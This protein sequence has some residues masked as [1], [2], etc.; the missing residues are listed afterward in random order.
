L[1]SDWLQRC[2]IPKEQSIKFK[3]YKINGST[4]VELDKY[5]LK[6]MLHISPANIVDQILGIINVLKP[7]GS[8]ENNQQVIADIQQ[9]IVRY[10]VAT[11][12]PKN[13][14]LT[15]RT[16]LLKL[17]KQDTTN[18]KLNEYALKLECALISNDGKTQQ[19]IAD[20]LNKPI[21]WVSKYY[22]IDPSTLIM[23]DTSSSPIAS[24]I[25]E[26]KKNIEEKEMGLHNLEIRIQHE[27]RKM[28]NF[29]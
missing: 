27:R 8:L 13:Q 17:L 26:I 2:G 15:E 20:Q 16:R 12:E 22:K 19:Q 7:M 23:P 9:N 3:K 11:T 29:Y 6:T 5:K 21:T 4:F 24:E 28:D 1:I 14:I 10:E 25:N 18:P